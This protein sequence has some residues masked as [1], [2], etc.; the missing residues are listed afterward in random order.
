MANVYE[1]DTAGYAGVKLDYSRG[2]QV[3][4]PD[5]LCCYELMATS[6]R[7]GTEYSAVSTACPETTRC[8]ATH[9]HSRTR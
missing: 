2:R 9:H 8:V 4:V 5:V 7:H 6:Q 3:D 1:G